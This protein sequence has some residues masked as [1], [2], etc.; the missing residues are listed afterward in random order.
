M[1]AR[2][3]RSAIRTAKRDGGHSSGSTLAQRQQFLLV[4]GNQRVNEFVHFALHHPI[5]LVERQI[6]TMVG[7]AALRKIIGADALLIQ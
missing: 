6:D 5:E 4:I 3:W 1:K 2:A 7:D